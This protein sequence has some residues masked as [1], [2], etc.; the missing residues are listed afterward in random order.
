M[1]PRKAWFVTLG[2]LGIGS[3]SYVFVVQGFVSPDP[4]PGAGLGWP[5]VGVLP[6]YAL[7]MWLLTAT[8]SRVALYVALGA[9]GALVG[10]AFETLVRTHP[11]LLT[12]PGYPYLNTVG[13][14]A[15]AVATVGLVLMIGAFPD[16]VI[17]RQW[18]RV[19]LGTVWVCLLVAPLTLLTTPHV[20]LPQYLGLSAEIDNPVVVP[21]LEWGA[22]LVD[23]LVVHPWLPA[24][25]GVLVLVSRALTGDARTRA[26]VRV[27]A[28]SVLVWMGSW[29][30][31]MITL[32]LGL[33][34]TPLGVAA[35]LMTLSMLAVPVALIH[36][37]LRYGAFDV[38]DAD[39][40]RL[41][42]RSS[43]TFI[44]VLYGIA[45]AA[46][47]LLLFDRLEP[48][49]AVLLTALAAVALLPLR[50][51]LQRAVTRAVLGDR[52]HH[53]ALLGE[54]GAR[55]E[56]AM[57]LDDVLA[58][59]A[60]GVRG[61]LD[62]SWVRVQV[63]GADGQAVTSPAGIAGD[64]VGDAVATQDLIRGDEHLGRLELGP[65][66][67]GEYDV[68]ELALLQT[69]ARQAT[70]TVAN[71]RLTARLNEQ[72]DELSASRMRLITAQDEERR[73][74]ERNLHDGIQQSVVALIAN[75]GRA[76]QRLQR[77]EL[78][79]LELV[80]LQ[81]QAREMLTDLRELAR[82]IHPQV[83]SD[84]GLVAAV[85]SRSSRFP[86]PLAVIAD[87]RAR[88]ARFAPD[89]EA[90]AFY[91]VREAL[92]N[93]A[94]HSEASCARVALS[95][96]DDRL[97]VEVVDDGS[98]FTPSTSAAAPGGLT[99]I[100]DRVAAVGG[101]LT[102]DAAPGGGT[103]L[104]VELPM[105]GSMMEPSPD[106]PPLEASRLA[107]PPPAEP[108]QAE[109]LATT[110]GGEPGVGDADEGAPA[111]PARSMGSVRA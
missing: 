84:R 67:R 61:G 78:R 101:H 22:P 32:E 40:A 64:V 90:V 15:D 52:E 35:G 51:W 75:L 20:V 24:S 30:L 31:W 107:T 57:E 29:V 73:R 79:P 36:G 71:V 48:V 54:L 46:P 17:E 102:V 92:A 69:V 88:A 91:T 26:R 9:T 19:A 72:L 104:A 5:L 103:R 56:Q 96:V 76:R 34:D 106:A 70:T 18:Q 6:L 111:P 81:D 3:L 12:T 93:V 99:N 110:D 16:G 105:A 58:R 39:R 45:V 109:P 42:V 10:S 77:D 14:T 2:V 41:V 37:I 63:L 95:V 60:E 7:G 68:A 108:S 21:W 55:L 86:V 94:K 62:A 1:I 38:A 44:A 65:R 28:C 87:E 23:D 82:G 8:S 89:I 74:I 33:R 66:R 25:L 50:G 11:D 98:G 59:L 4:D 97:R 47:A 83:L 43:T 100:R 49:S 53:V 80:E 27:M 85:E 13:I